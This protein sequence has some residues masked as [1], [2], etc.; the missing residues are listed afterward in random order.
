[1]G[2]TP[3]LEIRSTKLFEL[4]ATLTAAVIKEGDT[5]ETV[6]V[7]QDATFVAD[8]GTLSNAEAE[9]AL[10][11]AMCVAPY[12]PTNCAVT[13]T[14]AAD[15]RR[16]LQSSSTFD[17]VALIADPAH[18]VKDPPPTPTAVPGISAI[19]TPTLRRAVRRH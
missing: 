18:I 8:Q 4:V 17:F 13:K 11:L 9:A 16:A 3:G 5:V 19:G 10:T 1:M 7:Q 12:D 2:I 15:N 14:G 6:V